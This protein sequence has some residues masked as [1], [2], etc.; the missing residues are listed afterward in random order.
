[1]KYR[2]SGAKFLGLIA[3]I[4]LVLLMIFACS[5]TPSQGNLATPT[6]PAIVTQTGTASELLFPTPEDIATAPVQSAVA[7]AATPIAA[8]LPT[9][10]PYT[11]P[12]PPPT[13]TLLDGT[14]TRAVQFEGTPTPCR[15]CAPYRAEGGTWTLALEAGVFRVWHDGTNFQGIGSFTVSGDRIMLFNDPNCHLD[16]GVYTWRLDG[17]SLILAEVSDPCAF[18]LRARNLTTGAWLQQAKPEGLLDPCQPPSLEAA[19]SG[20]WPA[21]PGC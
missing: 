10:Y 14:Y 11:T 19:I 9:P 17:R 13:P 15:R 21:P 3:I 6:P 4:S 2:K 12:L 7:A 5:L 20:H 16:V 8:T 1:M 18:D